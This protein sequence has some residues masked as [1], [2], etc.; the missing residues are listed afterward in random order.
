MMKKT[1]F[2]I[3]ILV[4][5]L[6]TLGSIGCAAAKEGTT[7]GKTAPQFTLGSLG[8]QNI[9]VGPSNNITVLNFWATWCPPCRSEMPELNQFASQYSG[10]VTFYAINLQEEFGVVNDFMYKNSYAIPTLLDSDG[11]V[12]NLFRV[13]YLPTTIVIDRNGVIKYRKSGPVTKSELEDV[14]SQL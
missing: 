9:T 13:Q 2:M 5:F 12:A 6:L 4:I 7:V 3:G 1:R 10:K 8:G 11:A 14:I